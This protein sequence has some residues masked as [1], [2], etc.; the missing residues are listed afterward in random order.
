MDDHEFELYLLKAIFPLFPDS[1][2]HKGKRVLLKVGSEPGRL[3]FQLLCKCRLLG[4]ILY[5]GL[6]NTK[7]VSQDMN[8]NYGPFKT[9]FR[10]ILDVVVQ[11]RITANKSTSLLTWIVSLVVFSGTDPE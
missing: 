1:K 7:A 9:P 6:P 2:D 5:P 10:Q 3:N 11:N 4:F 8:R